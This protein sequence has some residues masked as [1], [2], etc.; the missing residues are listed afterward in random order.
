MEYSL[1]KEISSHLNDCIKRSE[2]ILQLEDDW[3]TEGSKGYKEET[4]KSTIDFLIDYATRIYKTHRQFIDIP[5]VHPGSNGSIDIEWDGDEYSLLINI[6][7]S[8][9][10]ATFYFYN[11]REQ[12]IEGE[13]NIHNY[14]LNLLPIARNGY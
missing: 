10:I 12:K 11:L 8:S 3:D 6:A 14:I 5:R 4:W 1:Q 13:F 7:E 9:R 2:Q